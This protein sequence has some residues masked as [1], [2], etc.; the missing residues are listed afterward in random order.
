M[1]QRQAKESR[2]GPVLAGASPLVKPDGRVSRIRLS[3]RDSSMNMHGDHLRLG[4]PSVAI[5]EAG[6]KSVVGRSQDGARLFVRHDSPTGSLRSTRVTR[7][8]RYY[9]P[10]RLPDEPSHSYLFL[11]SVDAPRQVGRSP[12]SL[13][14]LVNRSMPAVRSH[15]GGSDRCLCSLLGGRCQASPLLEGW[16]SPMVSRGRNRFTFVTADTFASQGSAQPITRPHAWSATCRTSNL[17]VQ[18]LSTEKINQT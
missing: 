16:P 4:H 7:L 12:G 9:E 15:P 8:R 5:S 3:R 10:L 13:R 14:F 2:R 6:V 17:H 1:A 18:S 11:W